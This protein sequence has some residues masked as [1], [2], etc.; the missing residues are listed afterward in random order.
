MKKNH[1][2]IYIVALSATIYSCQKAHITEVRP[3]A[4]DYADTIFKKIS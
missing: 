3:L 1:T 2:L 4:P